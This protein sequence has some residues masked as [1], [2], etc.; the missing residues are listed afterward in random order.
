MVELS[1]TGLKQFQILIIVLINSNLTHSFYPSFIWFKCI[2]I[3][4]ICKQSTTLND[5]KFRPNRGM[6]S[7]LI[8]WITICNLAFRPIFFIKII[9]QT[10]FLQNYIEN[11]DLKFPNKIWLSRNLRYIQGTYCPSRLA[12]P[13]R[14]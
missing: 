6:I 2:T 7:S 3:V 11:I 8:A 14:P 1:G 9:L 12:V 4:H 5:L 13:Y 10:E